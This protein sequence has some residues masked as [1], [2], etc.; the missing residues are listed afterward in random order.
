[1]GGVSSRDGP[2]NGEDA[3]LKEALALSSEFSSGSSLLSSDE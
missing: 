1:M 3:V 2:D